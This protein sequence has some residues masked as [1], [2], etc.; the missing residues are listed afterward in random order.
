MKR[1]LIIGSAL[2]ALS[3]LLVGDAMAATTPAPA[4]PSIDVFAYAS[5]V[6]DSITNNLT[7]LL[8]AAG[9]FAGVAWVMRRIRVGSR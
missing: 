6:F 1:V 3:A 5:G 4:A 9:L 8:T 2:A 7:A